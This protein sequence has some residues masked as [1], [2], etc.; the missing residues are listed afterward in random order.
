MIDPRR[1]KIAEQAH[2]HLPVRPGTDVVLAWAIAVELERLGGLDRDFIDE[3]VLGFEA[4]MEAA[5]DYPP[6]ARRRYAVSSSMT[7]VPWRAGTRRPRRRSLPGGTGLSA[8]K[9]AAR[10]SG[11][12]PLC[13]RWPASSA[14]RA[15][16]WSVA[17]VTPFRRRSTD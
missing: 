8:I 4:F 3:H 12:S 10:G 17:Q 5:R 16:A 13:Q 9:T 14:S 15:A 2:L 7:S 1:V 6:N 11:P